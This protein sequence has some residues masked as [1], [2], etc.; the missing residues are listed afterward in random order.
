MGDGEKIPVEKEISYLKDY[1]DL[2]KLRGSENTVVEF[3]YAP[4]VNGFLI[5]PLLLIHVVEPSFKHLS[6]FS[7]GHPN[8]IKIGMKK[9]KTD[10]HF[11]VLNTTEGKQVNKLD[12]EGGIGLANV[13]RRLELLYPGRHVLS[14]SSSGNQFKVDLTLLVEG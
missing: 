9:T 13:K 7:N 1:V 8:T 10:F 14:V 4:D 11:T 2:Q 3:N 12:K 6:P 5:E